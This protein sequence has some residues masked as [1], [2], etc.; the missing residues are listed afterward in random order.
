[1]ASAAGDDDGTSVGAALL[2]RGGP[3][4]TGTRSRDGGSPEQCPCGLG[5]AR[6]RVS[7]GGTEGEQRGYGLQGAAKLVVVAKL[8]AALGNLQG[9]RGLGRPEETFRKK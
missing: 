4:A 3:A 5:G 7:R 9:D 1:M 2:T 8:V 6:R